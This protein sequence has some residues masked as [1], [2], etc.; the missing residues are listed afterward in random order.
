MHVQAVFKFWFKHQIAVQHQHN[1]VTMFSGKHLEQNITL[2]AKYASE[3]NIHVSQYGCR[4]KVELRKKYSIFNISIYFTLI[5]LM[6]HLTALEYNYHYLLQDLIKRCLFLAKK[7][8]K[9]ICPEIPVLQYAGKLNKET[10]FWTPHLLY[11]CS[12]VLFMGQIQEPVWDLS[13][14]GVYTVEWEK[15]VGS[16]WDSYCHLLFFH[17][18][19]LVAPHSH[20]VLLKN[21]Q[22]FLLCPTIQLHFTVHWVGVIHMKKLAGF[23]PKELL[24]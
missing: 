16:T 12:E 7:K 20:R 8:K 10:E 23:G 19:W 4:C 9:K 3:R 15:Q 24:Q 6:K 1:F 11:V 22:G 5:F 14:W 21:Q 17:E 2:S 18:G 13:G